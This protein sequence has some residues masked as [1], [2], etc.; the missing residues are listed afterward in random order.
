MQRLL[1]AVLR[2]FSVLGWNDIASAPFDCPIELAVIDDARHPLGSPCIR[3]ADGWFDLDTMQTVADT[4]AL[5]AARRAA[6]ELLLTMARL[7][8][9]SRLV[10]IL[11]LRPRAVRSGR[12]IDRTLV[13]ALACTA[14]TIASA[15]SLVYFHY[16]DRP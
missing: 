13:L 1:T 15:V 12:R 5:L 3:R 4:L 10:S 11:L 6:D 9:I 2:W 16:L 14:L 7:A 8:S